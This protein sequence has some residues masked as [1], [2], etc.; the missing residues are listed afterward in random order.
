MMTFDS[1]QLVICAKMKE[2]KSKKIKCKCKHC[3]FFTHT[4]VP[5]NGQLVG[6]GLALLHTYFDL[7]QPKNTGCPLILDDCVA[8]E[9]ESSY[10][11]A[12]T[13]V[14]KR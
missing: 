3:V 10:V 7:R 2:S 4:A 1:N 6:K 13:R 9:E 8:V 12:L 14:F 11:Q 5:I